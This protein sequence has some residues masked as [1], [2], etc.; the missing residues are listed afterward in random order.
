M[1]GRFGLASLSIGILCSV[2]A[3]LGVPKW[4]W[5]IAAGIAVSLLVYAVLV[6][7][8]EVRNEKTARGKSE[9]D[10]HAP[11]SP[12]NPNPK[13]SFHPETRRPAD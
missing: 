5:A 3:A 8:P 10:Q 2:A 4:V 13:G 6:R 7:R 12:S 9:A 1:D 11:H